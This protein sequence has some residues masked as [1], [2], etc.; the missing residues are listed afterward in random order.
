M[1]LQHVLEFKY[2]KCV[3]DES[4][5][6]KAEYHRKVVSGRMVASAIKSLVNARS[7]QLD[8]AR[9]LHESLLVPFLTYGN[10]TMI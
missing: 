4:G 9:V 7:L 8:C 5:T 6:D 10:K 3:L 1:R 2:F